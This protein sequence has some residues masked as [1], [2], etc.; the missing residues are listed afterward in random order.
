MSNEHNRVNNADLRTLRERRAD[1]EQDRND[2]QTQIKSGD[3]VQ[4]NEGRLLHDRLT[5]KIQAVEDQIT[6]MAGFLADGTATQDGTIALGH[7]V[8]IRL[9]GGTPQTFMLVSESGGQQLAGKTTLSS[10]TPIGAA[11][12]GKQAGD[13]VRVP[14]GEEHITLE[15]MTCQALG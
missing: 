6:E 9:D 12:L 4:Q 5:R 1:L 13:T 2:T 14:V 15:I 7:I 10:G 3:E 11:M 8:T